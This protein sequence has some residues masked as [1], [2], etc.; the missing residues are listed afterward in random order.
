MALVSTGSSASSWA[1]TGTSCCLTTLIQN[2][3][4]TVS[5]VAYLMTVTEN[6]V[7]LVETFDFTLEVTLGSVAVETLEEWRTA[8]GGDNPLSGVLRIIGADDASITVT[9]LDEMSVQLDVDTNGDGVTDVTI[10]TTWEELDA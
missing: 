8:L 2:S 7:G 1:A 10:M 9:A 5:L 3:G 4:E 6:T